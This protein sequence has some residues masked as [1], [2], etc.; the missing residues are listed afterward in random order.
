VSVT[1]KLLPL[2]MEPIYGSETSAYIYQTPGNYPKEN[3]LYS[4]HGE[5]LKSRKFH[6]NYIY[7]IHSNEEGTI[8]SISF[9]LITLCNFISNFYIPCFILCVIFYQTRIY[10]NEISYLKAVSILC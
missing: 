5:S 4:E 1:L 6:K 8:L 2:K 10:V 7:N 9:F 3:L